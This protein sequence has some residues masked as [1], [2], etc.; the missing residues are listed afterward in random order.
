[1]EKDKKLLEEQKAV[2]NSTGYQSKWQS[3]IDNLINQTQNREP[4]KYNVNEDALYKQLTDQYKQQGQMAMMDTMGQAAAMTGGYGNSYAQS[5]GQQTYQG[6]MNQMNNMI[7]DL[8]NMALNRYMNEGDQMYNQ[9][10]LMMQQDDIDYGR[11]RDQMAAR[12][13]EYNKLVALMTGYGYTPTA[14]E[15]ASAGMTNA[16]YR[17]IMGISDVPAG[18][19]S[20]GGGGY[21]YIPNPEDPDKIEE[22]PETVE[23][24]LSNAGKLFEQKLTTA[25]GNI[26]TASS[27]WN[28]KTLNRMYNAWNNGELT[29]NDVQILTK[30][31]GL[32]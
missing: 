11:Y 22:D 9:L 23:N 13:D 7:P 26:G 15:M 32:G 27:D 20:G 31:F 25:K 12:E 14:D 5:V 8:Y 6:Y 10:N 18:D 29:D 30:E 28:T 1:M 21:N 19:Y 4:F 17:A 3:A 16:Q 2:Q 24:G